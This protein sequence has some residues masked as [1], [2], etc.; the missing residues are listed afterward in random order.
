MSFLFAGPTKT[1]LLWE[2]LRKQLNVPPGG[3]V[4][5]S[6]TIT[7]QFTT[8]EDAGFGFKCSAETIDRYIDSYLGRTTRQSRAHADRGT[9]LAHS[10]H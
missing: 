2:R 8:E 9:A 5:F 10:A 4:S 7:A 3:A 1:R 6:P